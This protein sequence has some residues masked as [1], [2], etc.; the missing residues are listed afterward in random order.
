MPA[1]MALTQSEARFRSN[2]M[3]AASLSSLATFEL[4]ARGR[5]W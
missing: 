5:H 4:A 3:A 1:L 2:V